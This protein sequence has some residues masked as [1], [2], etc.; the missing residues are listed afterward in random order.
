MY[1]DKCGIYNGNSRISGWINDSLV[2]SNPIEELEED[3]VV[4][5]ENDKALLYKNMVAIEADWLYELPE[6]D[7]IFDEETK[8]LYKV[9][10][11]S[12][13]IVKEA[14][15]CPNASAQTVVG[16]GIKM[17]RTSMI[18]CKL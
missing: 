7:A 9:Q 8:A 6:W 2:E 5:Q 10:K 11:S 15:I 14:K 4:S 16:S 12:T 18:S 17:L 3:T 13:T 1:T